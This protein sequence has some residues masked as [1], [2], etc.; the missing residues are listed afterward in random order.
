MIRFFVI[1][2]VI[3]C[4]KNVYA[5]TNNLTD[6]SQTT[7]Q[8]A[9]NSSAV[10]DVLVCPAGS[11]SWSK[12]NIT[13]NITLKGAGIGNTI[14]TITASGGI[15]APASYSGAF[16]LTGFTF[17]AS[18]NFGNYWDAMLLVWASK[19]FR[20]DHNEFQ[21]YSSNPEPA[22][23]GGVGGNGLHILRSAAGLIDGNR[24]V[25]G[26]GGSTCI[27]AA[28]QISNSGTNM[29]SD[30]AQ[31]YSWLNFDSN[32]VLGSATNTVFVDNNYFYNP[33]NCSQHNSHTIY[34]RH[35]G[36]VAFRHNEIHG[37]NADSHPFGSQHGGYVTEISNNSWINDTGYNLYNLIDFAGGTGVIYGNT[38]TGSGTS[39]GIQ[40]LFMRSSGAGGGSVTSYVPGYGTVSAD[41][42]CPS[43]ERYPCA[44][45]PGRGR[46]NSSDPLYIWGN[47]NFPAL[48]NDAGTTYIQSGRDYFLNAGAKPGY[49]SYTYPHPLTGG[50]QPPPP[51]PPPG[52]IPMPP[53]N[54]RVN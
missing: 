34:N 36:V 30:Q 45:Q 18:A 31:E 25:K 29:T 53:S 32:T 2:S 7:V 17:I 42:A 28:I 47:T 44:Q 43:T 24:F 23:A 48:L 5:A 41:T 35:G 9:I 39:I 4:S 40:L 11:W 50:E 3:V 27:H 20:I 8:N 51:L 49:K 14:I 38:F 15:T 19:G 13:K 10:G 22:N 37:F 26:G 52:L 21:I 46:N 6:C 54:I 12:V 16:R 1:I 33:N